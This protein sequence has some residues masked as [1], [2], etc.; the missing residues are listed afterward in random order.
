[1]RALGWSFVACLVLRPAPSI[2]QEGHAVG[3]QP[4][5]DEATR[6]DADAALPPP[7]PPPPGALPPQSVLATNP[8]P[9]AAAPE[10]AAPPALVSQADRAKRDKSRWYGGQTLA[11]DGIALGLLVLGVSSDSGELIGLSGLTYLL[12]G[13]IV[14]AAHGRAGMSFASLGVR[15]G[16]PIGGALLL[17]DDGDLV[18]IVAGVSLGILAAIATDSLL[19]WEPPPPPEPC[20]DAQRIRLA[21]AITLLPG[22]ASAG[23][24]GT[25]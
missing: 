6:E 12:G 24:L 1:M 14:H 4:P 23:L 18:G 8:P 3:S 10:R 5:L 22:G 25:F 7:P 15:I 11:M 16:F 2:A 9:V 13:P 19:A 20:G 17:G 21:P